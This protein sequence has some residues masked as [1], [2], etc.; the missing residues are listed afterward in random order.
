M[1]VF[2]ESALWLNTSYTKN[3]TEWNIMLIC[4]SPSTHILLDSGI[5][6]FISS[7]CRYHLQ[8]LVRNIHCFCTAELQHQVCNFGTGRHWSSLLKS[9]LG[10]TSCDIFHPGQSSSF[11]P[12][13]LATSLGQCLILTDIFALS[14][15]F[16]KKS[17]VVPFLSFAHVL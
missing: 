13:S 8:S 9:P 5:H 17:W 14:I 11:H 12:C 15:L 4:F 3:F 16:K 6:C 10:D 7:T 2:Q 1:T